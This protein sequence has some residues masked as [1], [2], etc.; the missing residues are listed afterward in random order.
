MSKMT[1]TNN[2][3]VVL[4]AIS[5]PTKFHLSG[6]K[7]KQFSKLN[8]VISKIHRHTNT[9]IARK[10]RKTITILALTCFIALEN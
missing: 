5:K 4:M 9:E 8:P 7:N 1:F 2:P 3:D 6:K 10:L